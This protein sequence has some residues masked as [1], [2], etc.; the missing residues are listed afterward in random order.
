MKPIVFLI[1]CLVV[2]KQRL[3]TMVDKYRIFKIM[4]IIALIIVLIALALSILAYFIISNRYVIFIIL[5]S[6]ILVMIGTQIIRI[7]K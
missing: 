4:N 6:I 3:I 1:E 7:R 2:V 5:W